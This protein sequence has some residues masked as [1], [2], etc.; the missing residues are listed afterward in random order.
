MR[1]QTEKPKEWAQVLKLLQFIV[2]FDI[3]C[4]LVVQE[5]E[6]GYRKFILSP[7]Q[8]EGNLSPDSH[9]ILKKMHETRGANQVCWV[10]IS[11]DKSLVMERLRIAAEWDLPPDF[12][13]AAEEQRAG[14]ATQEARKP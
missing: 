4:V 14:R 5:N 13:Q 6:T 1:L 7:D 2:H 12:Q 3:P 10:L 9:A 8:L 11:R